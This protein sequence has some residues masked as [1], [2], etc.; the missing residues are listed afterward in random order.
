MDGGVG[1]APT[2]RSPNDMHIC[3]W[4]DPLNLIYIFV[5]K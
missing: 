5:I 4:N 2:S 3:C 1:I